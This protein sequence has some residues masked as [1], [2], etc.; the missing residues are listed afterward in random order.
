VTNALVHIDPSGTGQRGWQVPHPRYQFRRR[1]L[2]LIPTFAGGAAEGLAV[3][4]DGLSLVTSVFRSSEQ[5]FASAL[6]SPTLSLTTVRGTIQVSARTDFPNFL[7]NGTLSFLAINVIQ[8]Q[9]IAGTVS[10]FVRSAH[11]S[12]TV[13]SVGF[14]CQ[15]DNTPEHECREHRDEEDFR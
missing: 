1:R 5:S 4:L 9:T 12:L 11:I 6:T 8:R 13:G 10:I 3:A 14:W 2:E 7:A 15:I